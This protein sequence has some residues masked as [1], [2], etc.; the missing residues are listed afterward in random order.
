MFEKDKPKYD[1]H[2]NP[3]KL[4][5]CMTFVAAS[6]LYRKEAQQLDPLRGICWMDKTTRCN[7][8]ISSLYLDD[9]SVISVSGSKK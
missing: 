5:Y 1:Q 9:G 4:D 3:T 8:E 6:I 2:Q 7:N